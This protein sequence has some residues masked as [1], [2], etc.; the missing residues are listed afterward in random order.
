MQW[1][2]PRGPHPMRAILFSAFCGFFSSLTKV[3]LSLETQ[4]SG[5][6][7]FNVNGHSLVA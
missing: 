3:V 4:Y 6:S 2:L 1:P 7:V 5:V